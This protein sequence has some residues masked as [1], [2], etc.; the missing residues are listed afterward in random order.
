MRELQTNG[1]EFHLIFLYLQSPELAVERVRE[2]VR[3]G[4]HN[5]PEDVIYRR[6]ANGL[7]NFFEIYQP[8]ANSWRILDVSGDTPKDLA[9]GDKFG[10]RILEEFKWKEIQNKK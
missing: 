9:F 4:G 5:I 7:K 1:Y 8:I 3:L 10:V 2:R 6:Y